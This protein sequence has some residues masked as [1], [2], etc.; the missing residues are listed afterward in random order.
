MG[1]QV[2][3]HGCQRF[4]R[5]QERLEPDLR[6][7]AD[8]RQRV[9]QCE[10]NEVV[11]AVRAFEECP[12]VIRVHLHPLVGVRPVGVLLHAD[13][14]NSRVDVDGIDMAGLFAQRD[15]HVGS[16]PRSDDQNVIEG[17]SGQPK[18]GRPVNCFALLQLPLRGGHQL[19]G[20]AVDAD[21]EHVRLRG[22]FLGHDL[23]VGRPAYAGSQR[24]LQ[25]LADQHQRPCASHEPAGRGGQHQIE[26]ESDEPPDHR[27]RMQKAQC[28]ERADA[29]KR[30]DQIVAVRRQRRQ[31]AETATHDFGRSGQDDCD[32]R[33][34]DRQCEP[35]GR[36]VGFE[37]GEID[38]V[39]AGPFDR[40]GENKHAH[41]EN[42]QQRH[43]YR[44]YGPAFPADEEARADAEERTQQDEIR[45][46]RQVDNVRA[47]PS[48]Q[49]QLE[50]EH[51]A[52]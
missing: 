40:D 8:Q 2:L 26:D 50:E 4:L 7:T 38:D 19:V 39:G 17:I 42:A 32:H 21:D 49:C 37:R 27:R 16:G 13:L 36:T 31:F 11:L 28:R 35:G 46:I 15:R 30:S 52:A 5:E 9:R 43:R 41:D 51:E 20:H 25:Q 14:E 33:E 47:E 24:L 18:I 48:D 6:G 22:D 3:A 1:F 45:K 10:K 44:P 29:E 23:V 12:P 34:N